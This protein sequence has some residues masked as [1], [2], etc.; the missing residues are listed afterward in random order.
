MKSGLLVSVDETPA[1]PIPGS[2]NMLSTDSVTTF[3]ALMAAIFLMRNDKNLLVLITLIKFILYL[4]CSA[5]C[6]HRANVRE[7]ECKSQQLVHVRCQ[8]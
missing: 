7:V 3:L 6:H 2:T 4:E 5:I 8:R 1:T